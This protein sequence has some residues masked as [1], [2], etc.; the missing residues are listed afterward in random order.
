MNCPRCATINLDGSLACAS[1]GAPLAAPPPG[2]APV[3]YPPPGYPPAG[4]YYPPPGYPPPYAYGPQRT[5]GLAIAGF[6]VSLVVCGLIGLILSLQG[7]K[8]INNS[9]GMVGGGGLATAGVVIGIIRLV[10]E[11]IYLIVVIWAVNETK[12]Y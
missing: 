1:C 2:P 10:L 6:V 3:G 11:V 7:K 12:H 8:E 9:G 5:S 4:G